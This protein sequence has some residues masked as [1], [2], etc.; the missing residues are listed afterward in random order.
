[1][2]SIDLLQSNSRQSFAWKHFGNLIYAENNKKRIVDVKKVYCRECLER[3][4]I[5]SESRENNAFWR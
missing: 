2:F 5:E 1:M 3:A 4:K